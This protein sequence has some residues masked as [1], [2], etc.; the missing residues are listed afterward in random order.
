ML[1][2]S[3]VGRQREKVGCHVS[4]PLILDL[5]DLMLNDSDRAVC[6]RNHHHD[7]RASASPRRTSLRKAQSSGDL[8]LPHA[9][10]PNITTTMS[11]SIS[12]ALQPSSDL[13]RQRRHMYHLTGVIVHHGRGF[14]SGHYTAYCLNDQPGTLSYSGSRALLSLFTDLMG[15]LRQ[16]SYIP[17]VFG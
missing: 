10:S 3:W 4:F 9:N 12:S 8:P 7:W 11:P 15:V 17:H 6:N 1:V 5:T 2:C 13:R 16:I 14:H